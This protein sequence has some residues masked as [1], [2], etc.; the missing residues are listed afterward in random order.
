MHLFLTVVFVLQKELIPTTPELF[1]IPKCKYYLLQEKHLM[2]V[3][4]FRI[5]NV[6]KS[7]RL[8][9]SSEEVDEKLRIMLAIHACVKW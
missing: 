5:R 1:S 4:H 9:W 7:L 3:C 6:S 8:S 2:L